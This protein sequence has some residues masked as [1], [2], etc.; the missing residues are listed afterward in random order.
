MLGIKNFLQI[1][2]L[3]RLI[4]ALGGDGTTYGIT[5]M[6]DTGSDMLTLVTTDFQLLGNTQGYSGWLLSTGV[7]DAS[8]NTTVFPTILVEVQLVRN[9]GTLW[10]NWIPE[11]AIVR[12]AVP[13]LPRLSGVGI[14]RVLYIGTAP[15]NHLLAA[16]T[17]KGGLASLL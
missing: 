2:M 15:G 4:P 9:N 16:S 12:Q 17:T 8:G 7:T 1:R 3:L 11:R 6:N 13:N 5:V 10:G 14:R